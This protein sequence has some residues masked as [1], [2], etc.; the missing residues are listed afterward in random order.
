[1]NDYCILVVD[2]EEDFCEILKFNFENEG[3]EV[4]I[5]NFVEEVLKMNISSYYLLLLDVM[6]GEIFGFKMV[7]LLKKD[8]KIV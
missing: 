2:D 1:M 8:K 4:D 6:M 3:Y 5:V 7:N